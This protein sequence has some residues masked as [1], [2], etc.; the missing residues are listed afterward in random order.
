MNYE[1]MFS[2]REELIK[3][4]LSSQALE[5]QNKLQHRTQNHEFV[6]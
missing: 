2:S 3:L 1:S 6:A 4:Q 5:D